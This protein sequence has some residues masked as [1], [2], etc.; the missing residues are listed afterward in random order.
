MKKKEWMIAG[1]A[2]GSGKTTLTL[3]ILRALKN[4]G[5]PVAPF[6]AG[7]DY[8][9]PMFHRLASG[10]PSTN[11]AGWLLS[12]SDLMELYRK[13]GDAAT[14]KVIEGV[15]GYFDG[16]HAETIEGSSAAL[17]SIL[18]V[19]VIIVFDASSMALTAAAIIS[20]LASFHA[21]TQIRGVIFNQVKTE[22]HYLL[23]KSA[24]EQHTN[25]KCYGYLKPDASVIMESRH[26][27][28]V[29][30]AEDQTIAWKIEQMAK[31]VEETV[32]L[33]GLLASSSFDA[34]D[35]FDDMTYDGEGM[36]WTRSL[37]ATNM[38]LRV[39]IAKDEAFSFY[40]DENLALLEKAGV[41]LIPFS[42]LKDIQL[43]DTI[44]GVYLGGGYPE[45]FAEI[46]SKNVDMR[47]SIKRAAQE[48]MPI[49]AE[50]G[51]LMFLMS[52]IEDLGGETYEMVGVFDGVAKMTDRLQR[53][54]H[55]TACFQ[56]QF[57][58]RGHEF[59]HSIVTR[60]TAPTVLSVSKGQRTWE[61]GF[62][63]KN[64]IATYVHAHFFA[65]QDWF[66]YLIN[67]WTRGKS[68]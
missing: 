41:Q 19:G 26:L 53:F 35:Y 11:L 63:F 64:V 1:V 50:C 51:G 46:L 49:Y 66:K 67:F 17:A 34:V 61:C 21:P 58:Y 10:Q 5:I 40:Y 45:V 8:I 24:V 15:M 48:G 12:E 68:D 59:H 42:P 57:S 7:P 27:G 65:S 39:A 6:K 32:D 13:R 31:M 14:V 44:N 36:Y 22:G 29:Q 16:H 54:G 47:T 3:G 28:L 52:A 4:R 33:D 9:D 25:I 60:C 43:P 62:A 2:S 38:P 30:A 37:E 20:G 18:N 55:V 23:L 56:N